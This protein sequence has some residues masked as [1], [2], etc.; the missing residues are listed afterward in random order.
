MTRLLVVDDNPQNLYMLQVLLSASG[1]AVEMASNGVEALERA[2]RVSPDLIISDILM[3]VMDGFALCRAWKQDERLKNIPF[4]FYTATY[5]DPK[6]EEFALS[7]GADRFIVKPVEPAK[8]LAL[9]QETIETHETV[10]SAASHQPIEEA[11]YYKEYNAALVRKLEDKLL[12]VEEA[13]RALQLDIAERKRAEEERQKLQD[14]LIQAYKMESVGRLAGGVA[15]DFNNMLGIILGYAEMALTEV[16][17]T[18]ALYADLKQILMA[19]ERSAALTRQ[20]LAFARK[21]A[22]RPQVLKLNDT[23]AGMLTMLRRLIGEDIDLVWMP[24]ADLWHVK[25]D[26]SQIDQLLANLC[27]NARDAIVGVGQVII[28]TSN[29]VFDEAYCSEHKG[30]SSGEYVM[31][32]VRDNGCGMDKETLL[33]IFEPFF[34]TKGV[35]QGTGLGLA[36]VYGIVKQNEGFINVCSEPLKGATFEIYLPRHIA[37]AEQSQTDIV[38]GQPIHGQGIVLLVED[39]PGLLRLERTMLEGLG[40]QV[41]SAARPSEAIR[42]A[43]EH[44]GEIHLLMTDVI[45]PEMNARDLSKQFL[46]RYPHMKQLFTSGYTADVIAHRGVLEE[47]VHFIQKPFSMNDLAAKMREVLD[48]K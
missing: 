28:E 20:L 4:I 36:T 19:V 35:G 47:G 31:L 25:M 40:Y 30:F 8:F 11:E 16:E 12:Q 21:Q 39:E 5:T 46:T 45:M 42:L 18:H 17:P 15:H 23:V 9:L 1:F 10:K 44:V 7:L 2:R 13:N 48:Q 34:T 22:I 38:V 33:H 6:D 26:P 43:K 32:S 24:G 41:L 14:Q 37:Q 3:P 29:V 27:A